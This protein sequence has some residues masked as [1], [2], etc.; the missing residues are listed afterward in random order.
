MDFEV[1]PDTIAHCE[2]KDIKGKN[3]YK[4]GN[5]GHFI[6][7]CPLLQNNTTQHHNPTPNHKQSY[8]SHS[9]SNSNN[10]EMLAPITQTLSNMQDQ[11][12]QLSMTNKT[13][14]ALPLM[15]KVITIIQTDININ[16]IIGIQN[17]R[18]ITIETNHAVGK[19]TIE[20]IT[21]DTT[22]GLGSMK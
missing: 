6:K 3:C 15:T 10:T 11:I 4:C 5:E 13:H 17:T 8:A 9:E 16:I 20:H 7:N 2:I 19:H 22:I 12:K 1:K 14:I 21:V 18:V